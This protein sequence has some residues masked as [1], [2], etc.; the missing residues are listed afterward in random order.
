MYY[1]VCVF[2][3]IRKDITNKS[4]ESVEDF[5]LGSLKQGS[6]CSFQVTVAR[7]LGE[8]PTIRIRH[9]GSGKDPGWYLEDVTVRQT[10]N[11]KCWYF[12]CARWLDQAQEDGRTDRYLNA[13]PGRTGPLSYQLQVQTG[14][15]FRAGT[16]SRVYATLS[17]T[18]G[19]SFEHRLDNPGKEFKAGKT[20]TFTIKQVW[21]L[22]ELSAL[23][24]RHDDTGLFPGWYLKDVRAE[25][26]D[27]GEVWYFPCEQWLDK[28]Q[29]D[30]F[31][32]TNYHV[33]FSKDSTAKNGIAE[34]IVLFLYGGELTGKEMWR[35]RARA[36][37]YNGTLGISDGTLYI[38]GKLRPAGGQ[39]E[40]IFHTRWG[41]AFVPPFMPSQ[42]LPAWPCAFRLENLR[43]CDD[44]AFFD[45]GLQSIT[46]KVG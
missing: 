3:N 46:G 4:C 33:V 25:R 9:D 18:D 28:D 11:Q 36:L 26:T 27:T 16:S 32:I 45:E 10:D 22:G 21:P 1:L 38:N 15:Q 24:I 34:D 39:D 13:E 5:E 29:G 44:W 41:R 43:W 12:P 8:I 7:E 35:S 23:R 6:E 37:W 40:A 30:A 20:D 14:D 31:I 17:G 19:S 42:W 2:R